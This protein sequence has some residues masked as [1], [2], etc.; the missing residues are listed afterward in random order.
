[1][2]P[3]F[4]EVDPDGDV[5]LVLDK[6]NPQGLLPSGTLLTLLGMENRQMHSKLKTSPLSQSRPFSAATTAAYL[7]Q[8]LTTHA[9]LT[10]VTPV[11]NDLGCVTKQS[12]NPFNSIQYLPKDDR[13]RQSTFRFRVSSKH[14]ILASSVFR[15]MLNGPWKEG[16]TSRESLRSLSASDWDVDALLML[17]N[18]VHG[19][20]RKV[21]KYLC[22]KALTNFAIIVDYYNCHEIVEIFADRWL[23]GMEG[24]LPSFH[25]PNSTFH[26]CVAW[27][28]KWSEQVEAMTQ[29]G[30]RHGEGPIETNLPIAEILEKIDIKRQDLIA[31]LFDALDKLRDSLRRGEEACSFEC[32]SMLF[33]C[34]MK[35]MHEIN[36]VDHPAKRPYTGYSIAHLMQSISDFQ[37]PR[38]YSL[39]D[40]SHKGRNLHSCTLAQKTQPIVDGMEKLMKEFTL[41]DV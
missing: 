33:G 24:N 30:L 4:Y 31:H 25:G 34:L 28:F 8:P 18:I 16:T 7:F 17:L 15:K 20:H 26:L 9:P 5:E 2:S 41:K 35:G 10:T 32:S 21:P 14:L 22:L 19:H 13:P 40:L 11:A 6:P 39:T 38:W 1:M 37:S 12:A 23:N 27:V 36:S 3:S 29:L